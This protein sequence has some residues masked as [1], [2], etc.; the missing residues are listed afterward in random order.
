MHT[1]TCGYY[2]TDGSGTGVNTAAVV[3]KYVLLDTT[4]PR[5]PPHAHRHLRAN[6]TDGSGTG[7]NTAA[8]AQEA[9]SSGYYSAASHHMHTGICGLLYDRWEWQA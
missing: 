1:G 5:E 6:T 9:C 2:T 4:A 7:V 8:V 3:R